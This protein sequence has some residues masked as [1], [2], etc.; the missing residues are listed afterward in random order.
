MSS[1]K[2][3]MKV[4]DQL[5]AQHEWVFRKHSRNVLSQ[6]MLVVSQMA[7]L[8]VWLHSAMAMEMKVW[9]SWYYSSKDSAVNSRNAIK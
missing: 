3:T 8:F 5:N 6:L 9:L 7:L 4:V 1:H 2:Q